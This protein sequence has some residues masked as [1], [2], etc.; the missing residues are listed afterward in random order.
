MSNVAFVEA[1]SRE[2]QPQLIP[3]NQRQMLRNAFAAKLREF[4]KH[5][6]YEGNLNAFALIARVKR[7]V[8]KTMEAAGATNA[9]VT[10][11]T[12]HLI[13]NNH[14][15]EILLNDGNYHCGAT[16]T[17]ETLWAMGVSVRFSTD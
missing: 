16:T 2:A 4:R 6:G 15:A 12:L 7:D 1:F 14:G 5:S 3:D 8:I 11:L 13:A 17:L 10:L 9:S